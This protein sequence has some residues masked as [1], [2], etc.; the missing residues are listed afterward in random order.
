MWAEEDIVGICYQAKPS[1]DLEDLV[2]AVVIC[3]VRN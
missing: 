1:S 3:K 2:H